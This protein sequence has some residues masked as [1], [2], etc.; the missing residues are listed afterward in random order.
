M[1]TDPWQPPGDRQWTKPP[2]AGPK[3]SSS[4]FADDVRAVVVT[5]LALGLLGAPV[6]LIW[7]HVAPRVR[8]VAVDDGV[9][10]VDTET[11]GFIAGDGWFFVLTLVFGVACGV[12][13]YVFGRRHGAVMCVA[14]AGG[15]LLA[16]F[17]AWKVGHRVDLGKLNAFIDHARPGQRGEAN[18]QLRAKGVLVGWGLGAVGAYGLLTLLLRRRIER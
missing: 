12:V 15:G 14:L 13:A 8:L 4:S 9:G 3:G 7:A 1:T 16:A 11:K 2:V 6:G 10:L 18:A 17:I 5:V